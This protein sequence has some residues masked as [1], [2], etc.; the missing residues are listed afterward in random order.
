[1]RRRLQFSSS[2]QTCAASPS[3]HLA[4]GRQVPVHD[5]AARFCG[6]STAMSCTRQKIRVGG[7]TLPHES[8]PPPWPIH[9]RCSATVVSLRHPPLHGY[10][11]QRTDIAGWRR[12]R[13]RTPLLS[14]EC[15]IRQP[16]PMAGELCRVAPIQP[17]RRGIRRTA[18]IISRSR[19]TLL[20]SRQLVFLRMDFASSRAAKTTLSGYGMRRADMNCSRSETTARRSNRSSCRR[21]ASCSQPETEM[22]RRTFGAWQIMQREPHGRKRKMRSGNVWLNWR[23]CSRACL[24]SRTLRR[25]PN[26]TSRR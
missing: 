18:A 21:T 10:R 19:D 6:F 23:A 15:L 14:D 26:S 16:T 9:P 8:T 11:H 12:N 4:L 25:Q 2:P 24:L 22:V 13:F 20:R 17:P 1:M 7:D 5:G 3:G